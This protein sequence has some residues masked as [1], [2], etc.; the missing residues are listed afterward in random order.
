LEGCGFG[1]VKS[2]KEH[3]PDDLSDIEGIDVV[4]PIRENPM[5]AGK[6]II[7]INASVHEGQGG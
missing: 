1:A 7:A 4:K 5:R 2:T 3:A 6:L